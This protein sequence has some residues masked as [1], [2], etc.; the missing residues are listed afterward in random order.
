M[1]DFRECV[2]SW[3]TWSACIDAVHFVQSKCCRIWPLY[4]CRWMASISSILWTLTYRVAQNKIPQQTICNIFATRGHWSDFKNSWSCLILTL[5]WI[6]RCTMYPLHLNYATT[7]PCKTITM[8]I[9]FFIIVLELKSNEA[10]KFDIS[11]CHSLFEDVFKVFNV[12]LPVLLW[13]F[14]R[15]RAISQFLLTQCLDSQFI[16]HGNFTHDS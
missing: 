14:C 9:T 1:R 11:D 15:D 10:W 16:I 6:Q 5:L 2:M 7:L 13:V 4:L 3:C 8:K 12:Q